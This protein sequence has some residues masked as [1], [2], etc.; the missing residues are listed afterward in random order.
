M[1]YITHQRRLIPAVATTYAIE[2]V[3]N[4]SADLFAK[5]SPQ[6]M[7]QVHLFA[8]GVKVFATW[9]RA[10][11]ASNCRQCCGGQGFSAYNKISD[12]I[13]DMDVDTTF[14]GDNTVLAQQITKYSLATY[15]T[16]LEKGV[17]VPTVDVPAVRLLLSYV[18][19]FVNSLA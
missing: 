9:H 2:S 19:K 13:T 16:R 7:K 1:S 8:A 17:A 12:V 4:K 14:E 10:E 18:S 11:T 15:A 5:R 6:T 3:L